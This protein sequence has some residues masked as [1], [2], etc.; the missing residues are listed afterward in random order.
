[1]PIHPGP[2]YAAGRILDWKGALEKEGS[3]HTQHLSILTQ[4]FTFLSSFFFRFLFLLLVLVL[5]FYFLPSLSSPPPFLL[6]LLILFLL[7]KRLPMITRK[8]NN[9]NGWILH[10]GILIFQTPFSHQQVLG[11]FTV[12]PVDSSYLDLGW[13]IL[14]R[15][16]ASS[17]SK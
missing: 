6:F 2:S 13:L 14:F 9:H 10:T 11:G 4:C 17:S 16:P 15:Q 8:H 3:S 12:I 7:L 1:M 5:F